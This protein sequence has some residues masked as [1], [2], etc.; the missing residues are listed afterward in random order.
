MVG[1]L[2]SWVPGGLTKQAPKQQPKRNKSL[3]L[4]HKHLGVNLALKHT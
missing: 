1:P 3:L 4:Y 2:S